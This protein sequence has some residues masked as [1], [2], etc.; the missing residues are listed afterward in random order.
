M[1]MT[2]SYITILDSSLDKKIGILDKIIGLN[3]RQKEILE[4]DKPDEDAFQGITEEKAVCIDELNELI[5]KI[6]G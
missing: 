5:K 3:A 1:S 4:A 2:E 6:E